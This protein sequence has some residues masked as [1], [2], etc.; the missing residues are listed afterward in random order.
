MTTFITLFIPLVG[1]SLGSAMECLKSNNQIEWV[2]WM[3]SIHQ[4][5][6]EIIYSV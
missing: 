5:I 2:G 3:N 6:T 1:T 4:M